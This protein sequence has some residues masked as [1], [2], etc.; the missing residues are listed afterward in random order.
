MLFCA[1]IE[2]NRTFEDLG[3]LL[4]TS[5]TH[6]HTS[7]TTYTHK[8][9][10]AHI[11]IIHQPN[12]V[13]TIKQYHSFDSNCSN[14]KSNPSSSLCIFPHTRILTLSHTYPYVRHRHH[15][16]HTSH[17][18]TP[19]SWWYRLG[20]TSLTVVSCVALISSR[21]CISF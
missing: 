6:I 3:P 19:S 9:T 17:R 8:L 5:T 10:P 7:P 16:T 13:F 12:R 11:H 14:N 18:N 21:V 15:R 4:R 1:R 20:L 2:S